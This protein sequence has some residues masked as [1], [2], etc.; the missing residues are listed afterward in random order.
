MYW[1]CV[2]ASKIRQISAQINSIS[3]R[4]SITSQDQVQIRGHRLTLCSLDSSVFTQ[5]HREIMIHFIFLL[6]PSNDLR[7]IPVICACE[8]CD[9]T[10]EGRDRRRLRRLR[11]DLLRLWHLSPFTTITI[12]MQ[13][14]LQT[15][16][17]MRKN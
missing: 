1:C 11:R 14:F 5:K 4:V 7:S 3:C 6:F 13:W 8:A 15:A 12:K 9:V 16:F 2:H 17:K 10:Q